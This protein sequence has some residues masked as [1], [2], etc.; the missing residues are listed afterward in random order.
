M[1]IFKKFE[2]VRT[3]QEDDGPS[4]H[5]PVLL[6]IALSHCYKNHQRMIHYSQ[7]DNEFKHF[8]LKF[9]IKGKFENSYYPFG[10]LENDGIW[11]VENSKDLMRTSVGHLHK[12]ELLEKNV[13]G[14]FSKEIQ[15]LIA[16]DKNIAIKIINQLLSKYFS[17]DVHDDI[18]AYLLINNEVDCNPYTWRKKSVAL[19]GTQKF[20]ISRWWLSKGIEL[21][22]T[23]PDIFSPKNIR[24][25]MQFFIAGSA[26]IKSINN[27][28]LAAQLIEKGKYGLTDFGF[29]IFKNDPKLLKSSTWWAIHLSLC[30]SERGEPYIQLFL[31]LDPLIKEWILFQQ[32]SER[33]YSSIQD[34]A[35]QSIDSNLD[36]VKKMFVGDTP[37]AEIGLIE[38][39]KDRQGSGTTVRLGSPRLTD[40]IVNIPRQ[41]RGLYVVNRSKR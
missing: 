39:R 6:L 12:N 40:E 21:I 41:S 25:A 38:I 34:A 35:T 31:K 27:W 26:V 24:E 11:E 36:G 30:F 15:E 5:K 29:S 19:I 14:G 9:N 20:A 7:L 23:K 37:F 13:S 28:M 22:Q 16:Q 8:F 32:L 17:A 3:Y 4:L 33:I 2:S 1:D 10:K 18:K